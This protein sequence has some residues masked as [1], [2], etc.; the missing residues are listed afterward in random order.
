MSSKTEDQSNKEDASEELTKWEKDLEEL[1]ERFK[2]EIDSKALEEMLKL[3]WEA[4]PPI[5]PTPTPRV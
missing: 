3:K 5:P 2:W 4:S 1:D